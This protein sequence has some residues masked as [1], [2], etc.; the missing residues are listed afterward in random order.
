MAARIG[1]GET[2][3]VII[4]QLRGSEPAGTEAAL[5]LLHDLSQGLGDAD[6][7]LKEFDI[8]FLLRVNV[9]AGDPRGQNFEDPNDYVDVL[10]NM[11]YDSKLK[12]GFGFWRENY[13]PLAGGV[14]GLVDGNPNSEPGFVGVIARGYDLDRYNFF[15]F[16]SAIRPVES[17]AV[18]AAMHVFQPHVSYVL[19]GDFQKSVCDIDASTI[20]QN[21][22]LG[23]LPVADCADPA[24]P[25]P[26]ILESR[27]FM[28]EMGL[29][30]ANADTLDNIRRA[31]T[32][33]NEIFKKL[34]S[35]VVGQ[36]NRWSQLD[37][38]I[39]NNGDV[40]QEIS[41]VFGAI[42]LGVYSSN[43]VPK[44]RPAT[45]GFINGQPAFGV[46]A[47]QI[48]PCYLPDQ[49]CVQA[50]WLEEALKA[51]AAYFDVDLEEDDGEQYCDITLTANQVAQF[52]AELGW[53]AFVIEELV[54]IPNIPP[55]PLSVPGVCPI[56][57]P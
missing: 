24:P 41:K 15:G 27:E 12:E 52:P 19:H 18:V 35:F 51:T 49:I 3:L 33:T 16:D 11:P 5:N 37:S 50:A 38:G 30:A 10:Q 36:V 22:V 20:V 4:T 55:L 39:R 14:F 26:T 57:D 6:E 7:I 32:I 31:H 29:I 53:Q 54:Q 47:T 46:D 21:A 56:P 45:I 44:L 34:G 8:L 42:S 9:D 43:Y 28:A 23:I 2:K 48:E 25:I 1:Y 13:D 40:S 17:Q